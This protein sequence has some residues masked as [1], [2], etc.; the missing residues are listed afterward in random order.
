MKKIASVFAIA[1]IGGISALSLNHLFENSKS[2]HSQITHQIPVKFANSTVTPETAIDF[3][4]AASSSVHAVVNVKTTYSMESQQNQYNYDPFR[5]FFGQRAPRPQEAPMA[6]GSGVIVT[7]DGYIVT[8]NHVVD[9]AEKIEITLNDKRSYTA[10]VIGKDPATD[11]ALL[12]IKET[13]LPFILYGNSDH[14]KV[15]EWVLAVG[16]PFNLTSTVTAG[17]ISAKGRNI[18][19]LDNDQSKGQFPIE[20]FIQTDAA[21]N[22]G[23]SGGALVNT[24]GELVGINSAIASNTG[25]YTGYSFA[26]PVNLARKVVADL[27]EF[28]EVQRAFI[29]V[30]IRDLDSKLAG[31]KSIKEIKGVYVNGLTVGGSAEEAGIKEGDVITKVGDVD[32]NNVPEL[33]EQVSRYRPGDK[34]NVTLKRNNQEKIMNVILKNKNGTID[35]V[36]KPKVEVVSAL[37]ATFENINEADMKKLNILN[38][39]KV[40]KLNAGKLLSAGIREGFIITGVDKKKINSVEDIKTALENKKGG[41]L[42]EGIYPNGMRAYYGFGM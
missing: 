27:V 14:V 25:S 42:I 23:N 22:P 33:Q 26:I 29:G 5:D 1:S 32:V 34:V 19:I 4:A 18:N 17:I 7:E 36:E 10:E 2:T 16:N 31:E 21:V 35:K 12:K 37:G 8:N 38:G 3:T 24:K 30:S 9:G 39:L 13:N 40:T 41:V 6:T 20:S 15:G 28:G 11:L